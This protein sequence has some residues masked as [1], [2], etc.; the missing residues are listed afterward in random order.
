MGRVIVGVRQCVG[1][2]L[3]WL[4]RYNRILD[5]CAGVDSGR[6]SATLTAGTPGVLHGTRTY[7]LQDDKGQIQATHSISAV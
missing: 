4:C 3:I 5:M 1:S 7:L 6:H 2:W